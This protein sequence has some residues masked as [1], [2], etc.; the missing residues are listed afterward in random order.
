MK[1]PCCPRDKTLQVCRP[2]GSRLGLRAAPPLWASRGRSRAADGGLE[3]GAGRTTSQRP[4]R[5]LGVC[6]WRTF[7][8]SPTPGGPAHLR[9]QP[10]ITEDEPRAQKAC[11]RSPSPGVRG[12]VLQR[13]QGSL[14]LQGSQTQR[15]QGA[16]VTSWEIDLLASGM[17]AQ[18][19]HIFPSFEKEARHQDLVK[20]LSFHGVNGLKAFNILITLPPL[21]YLLTLPWRKAF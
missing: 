2:Q 20:Y 7:T 15:L 16:D 5:H 8:P 6:I 9:Y 1:S 17:R 18:D 14:W 4:R 12:G 19:G 11:P 3:G 13:C 10:T 21:S